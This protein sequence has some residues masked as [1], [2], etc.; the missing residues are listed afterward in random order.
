MKKFLVVSGD[1]SYS[2]TL[3]TVLQKNGFM[4]DSVYDGETAKKKIV[5]NSYS[6]VLMSFFLSDMNCVD[7]VA[8][9][10][11]SLPDALKIV[12]FNCPSLNNFI[13]LAEAGADGIWA[14]STSFEMLV[15]IIKENAKINPK[16]KATSCSID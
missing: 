13:S 6:A 8:F 11:R 4:V 12:L 1:D 3:M 9:L 7:L 15:R 16:I 5:D 2:R 14:K 10:K